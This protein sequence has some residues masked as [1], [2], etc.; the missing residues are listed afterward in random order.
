MFFFNMGP[1]PTA[2]A[3]APGVDST[4]KKVGT[5]RGRETEAKTSASLPPPNSA[6]DNTLKEILA[7][8]AEKPQVAKG[9]RILKQQ[10]QDKLK[11]YHNMSFAGTEMD[12][13]K[14]TTLPLNLREYGKVRGAINRHEWF[15][16]EE[17]FDFEDPDHKAK[18]LAFCGLALGSWESYSSHWRT[19][20]GCGYP[21]TPKGVAQYV[22]ANQTEITAASS[23]SWF[24]AVEYYND[25]M[26]GEYGKAMRS[27]LVKGCEQSDSL[28]TSLP[29]G[30]LGHDELI[31][32]ITK[33]D[34]P[35]HICDGLV[36]QQASGL[37]CMRAAALRQKHI[38]VVLTPDG[39]DIA[40][41]RVSLP[42]DK[43]SKA[44]DAKYVHHHTDPFWNEYLR[45]LWED[46]VVREA[47]TPIELQDQDGAMFVYG[48]KGSA[49]NETLKKYAAKLGWSPHLK[50]TTHAGKY[51]AA[52]E[53][54]KEAHA[55]GKSAQEV[56][57]MIR[58]RTGHLTVSMA[59]KYSESRELK[60]QRG[61][62]HG[63]WIDQWINN[64]KDQ[65]CPYENFVEEK[66]ERIARRRR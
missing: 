35:R 52:V 63:S 24:V 51:G 49:H 28:P 2:T 58:D 10:M 26:S 54:A 62:I 61:K 8:R 44:G 19:M 38:Q 56:C 39:T 12:R 13:R 7:S 57:D 11:L 33:T 46:A 20:K 23:K 31:Q 34:L 4:S 43:G 41:F 64:A 55:Q 60:V 66:L 40:H 1:V 25:I 6:S 50:W 3:A 21:L 22:A 17:N 37:R 45:V 27:H 48:Y 16:Q 42:R 15:L 32:L 9:P 29:T 47:E 18:M 65:T 59:R 14:A 30:D 53:A 36:M 5:R